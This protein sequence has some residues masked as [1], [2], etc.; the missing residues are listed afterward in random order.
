MEFTT[1]YTGARC[2]IKMKEYKRKKNYLLPAPFAFK[3]MKE[4]RF[5]NAYQS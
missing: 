4:K 3:A 5:N 2:S 1:G